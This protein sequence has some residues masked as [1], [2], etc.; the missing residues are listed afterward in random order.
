VKSV[1]YYRNL[2]LYTDKV[3]CF[4]GS[5]TPTLT[6]INSKIFTYN[7]SKMS[8]YNATIG[9][10]AVTEIRKYLGVPYLWGGTTPKGFD[11]SGLVQYV[12]KS[13]GIDLNRVSQDQFKQGTPLSREE[14]MPG[15]LVF[16]EENGDVHHVGM[17]V[18]D[19]YMIHAPYT[20]AV[21]SYQSI[22]TPYYKSQFC[23]GRRVY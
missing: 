9:D 17:Y 11:C 7:G 2:A 10:A 15:D 21:V 23:G 12:Y 3:E 16:F 5:Q 19:G 8:I 20:G 18:G 6:D 1:A 4:I 13:L 22:D 14:L